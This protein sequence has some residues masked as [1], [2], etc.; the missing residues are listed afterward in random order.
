MVPLWPHNFI[1]AVER[2]TSKQWAPVQILAVSFFLI[3][4]RF[5]PQNNNS[6]KV[7]W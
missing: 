3:N 2:S 6:F 1:Q 5:V 4:F 7:G